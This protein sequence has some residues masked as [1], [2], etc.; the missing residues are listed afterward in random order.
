[1]SWPNC[2]EGKLNALWPLHFMARKCVYLHV[3]NLANLDQLPVTGFKISL[4]PIKIE[5]ESSV[6]I[7]TIGH[8][9]EQLDI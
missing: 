7:S 5:K 1:M 3:E 9:S 2:D 6:W 4:F 8:L